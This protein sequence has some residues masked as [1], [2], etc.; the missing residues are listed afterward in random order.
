MS[1]FPLQVHSEKF[2][3]IHTAYDYLARVA[4]YIE[5]AREMERQTTTHSPDSL[6]DEL[7]AL[8]VDSYNLM[9]HLHQVISSWE[10]PNNEIQTDASREIITAE[11]TTDPGMVYGRAYLLLHQ[12]ETLLHNL[13]LD[14]TFLVDLLEAGE[15]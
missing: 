14:F 6:D 11:E 10:R 2:T 5:R 8:E 12:Y 7:Q 9:C 4:I 3:V 1:S 15:R 13:H